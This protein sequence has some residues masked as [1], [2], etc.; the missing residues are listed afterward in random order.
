MNSFSISTASLIIM[1]ISFSVSLFVNYDYRRHAKSVC[2]PSSLDI[3]SLEYV[4][5]GINPLFFNQNIEQKD[6]E[7]NTPS[8]A[9]NATNLTANLSE[10]L[11]Y[12]RAQLAFFFIEGKFSTA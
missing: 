11:M 10:L 2:N 4:S 1:Y 7:K 8:T 5:P 9:A 3:N 12:F 6:P